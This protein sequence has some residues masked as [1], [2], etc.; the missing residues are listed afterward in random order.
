MG[1]G[2]CREAKSGISPRAS[3]AMSLPL[4]RYVE[5]CV[6]RNVFYHAIP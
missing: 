5:I 1:A 4:Q 2:M 6:D 3:D